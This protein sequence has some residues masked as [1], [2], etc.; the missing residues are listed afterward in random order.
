MSTGTV[1]YGIN[2][3][4]TVGS[5]DAEVECRIKGKILKVDG[6]EHNPLAPGDLV[7]FHRDGDHPGYGLITE[8]LPRENAFTRWN[9]KK[10]RIQ[11]LAANIDA[12]ACVSSVGKPPF[13]P[14]FIDRVILEAERAEIP[15]WIIINKWDLAADNEVIARAA[16]FERI[17]Y[18][19]FRCSA[20]TGDGISPLADTLM[21]KRVVFLGQ[22]GVGKSTLLNRIYPELDLKT[23]DISRKYDRGAHTTVYSVMLL[24]GQ[25][26]VIDT[27]GIREIEPRDYDYAELAY[28][29]REFRDYISSCPLRNC[30]HLDEPGCAVRGAVESGTILPDRYESYKKIL[31]VNEEARSKEYD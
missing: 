24:R 11:T 20:K 31:E 12:V 16:D 15:V 7:E 4:F 25:G 28:S 8:R 27:P 13:R 5:D 26:A 21:G 22:S 1:L 23:G 30:R 14:R 3:I 10:Q 17:G 2:N 9:R 6:K 29:F 19:V 18:R